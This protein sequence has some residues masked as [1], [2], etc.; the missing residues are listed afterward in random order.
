MRRQFSNLIQ[1]LLIH[2]DRPGVDLIGSKHHCEFEDEWVVWRS[3]GLVSLVFVNIR[4]IILFLH[5]VASFDLL[6]PPLSHKVCNLLYDTRQY[7]RNEVT[8]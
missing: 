6:K 8:P 4:H 7:P 1:V 5:V 2:E 3:E